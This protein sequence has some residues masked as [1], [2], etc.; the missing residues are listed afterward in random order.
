MG[1]RHLTATTACALA[2]TA[3]AGLSAC[4]K[5]LE[6]GVD[7]PAREGLAIDVGGIDYNVYLT[8]EL[9]LE[10]APD[11]AYYSGKPPGKG[12]ALYGVFV[13]TCN[14]GSKPRMT[15]SS[16]RVEDNQGAEFEPV[17]IEE[18]NAFAYRPRRLL[19][20]DCIPEDGSVAQLGPTSASMLLFDFPLPRTENRPLEL[21]IEAPYD[22]E[23]GKREVKTVELDL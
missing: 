14:E 19:P 21:K 3:A 20:G 18:D 6:P 15:A 9:N 13:R 22:F 5:H 17:E 12:R 11:S 8:R 2:L 4:G 7:E 16:F 1:L 10:I 23:E